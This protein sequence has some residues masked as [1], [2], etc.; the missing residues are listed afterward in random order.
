MLKLEDF[1]VSPQENGLLTIAFGGEITEWWLRES[2]NGNFVLFGPGCDSN[3]DKCLR[4]L[5]LTD[6]IK[7][8]VE[9]YLAQ[10][11]INVLV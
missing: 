3:E 8:V 2:K 1:S 10:E 6:A 9:L 5:S 11:K 4:F 7:Q